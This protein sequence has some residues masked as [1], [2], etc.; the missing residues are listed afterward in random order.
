MFSLVLISFPFLAALLVLMTRKAAVAKWMS[1]GFSLLQ[2]AL[3]LIFWHFHT[4]GGNSFSFFL[5]WL[6][7]WGI[8]I[9]FELDG[10]S[11]LMVLL[12]N[13]L[14]PFIIYSGIYKTQRNEQLLYALILFTQF[15]LNGVFGSRNAVLFYIFWEMA[16]VPVFFILFLWG[17][18]RRQSV[19]LKFFIYTLFGSLFLMI[20]FIYLYFQTSVPHD[21]EYTSF[22][23]TNLEPCNQMWVFWMLLMSFVIKIPLFPVHTWQPD[24]YTVAPYQGSMLLGGL[25]MKMG[26]Y[27]L[28]RWV[29]PVIPEFSLQW[30]FWIVIFALTG[31]IYFSVIAL[32]QQNFKMLIAFSSLAHAGLMGA[33]VFSLNEY[34]LQGVLFQCFSHGILVVLLFYFAQLI[35]ERTDTLILPRLGGIKTPAPVFSLLLL[36]TILGSAGLPLTN[37]FIGE[38]LMILGLFSFQVWSSILGVFTLV[39]GAIYLLYAYQRITLGETNPL[40]IG[41]QDITIRE[42][43]LVVPLVLLVIFFGFYPQ[44]LL[45]LTEIPVRELISNAFSSH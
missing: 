22:L 37:G 23:K 7:E 18:E 39:G 19:T 31:L 32:Q 35:E 5:P 6:P 13:L 1:L 41:F 3:T 11:F 2:L 38:I 43:V 25:M 30:G 42:M 40:T 27:G 10:I 4:A 28:I 29:L 26:I 34:G 44:P 12:T 17:G 36:I 16:L 45:N 20:A 24:T 15:A 33:A 9:H 21:F 14:I 8:N